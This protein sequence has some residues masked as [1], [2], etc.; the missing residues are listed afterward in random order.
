MQENANNIGNIGR[1]N[2]MDKNDMYLCI[3]NY[4]VWNVF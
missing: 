1:Y 3:M 2:S 4:L